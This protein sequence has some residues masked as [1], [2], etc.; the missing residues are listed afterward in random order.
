M[1]DFNF[2]HIP[3][4]RKEGLS[5]VKLTKRSNEKNLGIIIDDN[6]NFKCLL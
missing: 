4:E 5:R 6:L 3:W 1:G 2:K